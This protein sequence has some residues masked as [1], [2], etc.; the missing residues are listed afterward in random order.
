M[1]M[2]FVVLF[3]NCL[4]GSVL[5]VAGTAK[6]L[7][8]RGVR[9]TLQSDRRIAKLLGHSGLMIAS[10]ILPIVELTLGFMIFTDESRF[11]S[12][13]ALLLFLF[14]QIFIVAQIRDGNPGK[15]NCFG[16]AL[17]AHYSW[18]TVSRN[19]IFVVAA[20]AGASWQTESFLSY[21]SMSQWRAEIWFSLMLA[22]LTV[23]L[24]GILAKSI[25]PSLSF[26]DQPTGPEI[27]DI[28]GEGG[29]KAIFDPIRSARLSSTESI[30][31]VFTTNECPACGPVHDYLNDMPNLAPHR[32]NSP[33]VW[34]H[35]AQEK[36]EPA[37]LSRDSLV[38]RIIARP[39]ELNTH[40]GVNATP[41]AYSLSTSGEVLSSTAVGP[42][43]VTAFLSGSIT[44]DRVPE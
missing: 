42:V 43:E 14:F 28:I 23:T 12:L 39:G 2:D 3:C 22:I 16:S 17:P 9:D 31:M 19:S 24:L 27:G 4:I 15:C 40:F 6:S 7:N 32:S 37:P 26:D 29:L 44:L 34:I 36:E 30:S 21:V 5:I 41:S 8:L 20:L 18:Q 38:T 35:Q 10:R 11:G 25:A 13:F 33:I 1:R